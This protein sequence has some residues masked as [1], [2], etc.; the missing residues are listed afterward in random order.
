MNPQHALDVAVSPTGT[1]VVVGDFK[2]SLTLDATYAS[3]GSSDIFVAQLTPEGASTWT[4][5][6]GGADD[7]SGVRIAVD[8]FGGPLILGSFANSISLEGA[9]SL[10]LEELKTDLSSRLQQTNSSSGTS[11]FQSALLSALRSMETTTYFLRA[12][13]LG[14]SILVQGR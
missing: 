9:L 11:K 8:K 2:G 12:F 3:K 7:D 13:S 5:A 6:L 4:A 1:I 10:Q 14:A